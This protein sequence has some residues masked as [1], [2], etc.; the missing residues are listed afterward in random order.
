MGRGGLPK[1][2]GRLSK[3]A[4]YQLLITNDHAE[5]AACG[6]IDVVTQAQN[7]VTKT[8]LGPRVLFA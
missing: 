8:L 7:K 3:R 6:H 4:N 1:Q 2:E 5:Y